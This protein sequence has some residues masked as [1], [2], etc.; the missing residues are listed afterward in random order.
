[1][2]TD[3]TKVPVPL[4][5]PQDEVMPLYPEES[6]VTPLGK[7]GFL[8]PLF[9]AL[10]WIPEPTTPEPISKSVA[11]RKKNKGLFEPLDE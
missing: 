9:K 1:V 6:V 11:K 5:D 7:W 10:G 8:R 2:Q 3:P 4:I